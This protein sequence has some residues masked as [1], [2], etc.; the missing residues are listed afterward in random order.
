LGY[1]LLIRE[2]VRWKKALDEYWRFR[3]ITFPKLYK[4]NSRVD[5]FGL[6]FFPNSSKKGLRFFE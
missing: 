4:K 2:K 3:D 6:K 1:A 5:G